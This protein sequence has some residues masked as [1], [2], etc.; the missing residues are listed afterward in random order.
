MD[1][2]T[3]KEVTIEGV[4]GD[5]RIKI[6]YTTKDNKLDGDIEISEGIDGDEAKYRSTIGLN[7]EQADWLYQTLC[8]VLGEMPEDLQ[9]IKRNSTLA[10]IEADYPARKRKQKME[11]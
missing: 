1:A 3:T 5:K 4:I 2:T 6:E 7:N 8:W 10:Q 11:A 9:A